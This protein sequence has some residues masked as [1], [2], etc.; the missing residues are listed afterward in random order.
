MA[1]ESKALTW[2]GN[3]LYYGRRKML[4]IVPDG[5]HAGMYRVKRPDATLTDMA[6]LSWTKD[7][8]LSIA[9]QG[10]KRGF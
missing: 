1:V 7:A 6:N 5:P 8:G 2:R 3:E 9:T 4:E 10:L